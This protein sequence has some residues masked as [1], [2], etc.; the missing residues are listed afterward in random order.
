MGGEA[1]ADGPDAHEAGGE[2]APLRDACARNWDEASC[3]GAPWRSIMAD[4]FRMASVR[5]LARRSMRSSS[6]AMLDRDKDMDDRDAYNGDVDAAPGMF[7]T[8]NKL[9]CERASLSGDG[10]LSTGLSICPRRIVEE[11]IPRCG[12]RT[13]WLGSDWTSLNVGNA[14]RSPALV[15]LASLSWRFFLRRTANM[16]PLIIVKSSTTVPKLTAS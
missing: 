6:A 2:N 16:K 1:A 3:T 14:G 9:C 8:P 5:A 7:E 4:F 13:A 15:L 12:I 11:V 10:T